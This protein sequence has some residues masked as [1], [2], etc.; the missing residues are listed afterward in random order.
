MAHGLDQQK[1][2]VQSGYWLLNRYNPSLASEGQN[3]FQIDS[4]EP[5]I[6]LESFL[7]KERRY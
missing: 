4:R 5:S 1:A 6:P 7:Y 2:A 3:P